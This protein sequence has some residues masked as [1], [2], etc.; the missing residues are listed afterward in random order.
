MASNPQPRTAFLITP[1][2]QSENNAMMSA[3]EVFMW[4]FAI[5]ALVG[6]ITGGIAL[7]AAM[8]VEVIADDV[9]RFKNWLARRAG[10]HRLGDKVLR[11]PA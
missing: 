9:R 11:T 3:F 8:L 2:F 5:A 10:A 1:K 6:M 4:I 7:I